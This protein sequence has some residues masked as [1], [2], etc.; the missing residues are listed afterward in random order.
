MIRVTFY[1]GAMDRS[2]T[3]TFAELPEDREIEAIMVDYRAGHAHVKPQGER[4]MDNRLE[5]VDKLIAA[6]PESHDD[7]RELAFAVLAVDH[8]DPATLNWLAACA[9]VRAAAVEKAS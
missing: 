9:A 7:E 3:L 2:I 8:N 4:E 1:G 6:M 5:A